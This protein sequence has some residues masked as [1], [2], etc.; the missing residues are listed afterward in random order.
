LLTGESGVGKERFADAI[1]HLSQRAT[2]PFVKVNCA[3]LSPMLVESE[4][5]GH[6]KGAFTG[7]TMDRKG[8]FEEAHGGTLLLDEVGELP[9]EMQAKLLRFLQEGEL[10]RIGEDRV[11]K[12]DVRVI[13]ATN[14]NLE[15]EIQAG[16]FRQDLYYRL[17]GVQMVIPPLRERREDIPL[18]VEHILDK[19][20]TDSPGG[21]SLKKPKVAEEVMLHFMEHD[22]PGNVRELVQAL[23]LAV[24]LAQKTGEIS[25]AECPV[26]RTSIEVPATVREVHPEENHSV[27]PF[28]FKGFSEEKKSFSLKELEIQCITGA[29]EKADG[30]ITA[31]AKLLEID[32]TTLW[33][34][35]KKYNMKE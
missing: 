34:K 35:L 5:F 16:H 26:R 6:R 25:S 28:V 12:V 7:A 4:L 33:R 2:K 23:R 3:A 22:W 15:R 24:I 20:I 27:K 14:R 29:L 13:A 1:H 10:Q 17:L 21:V 9:L 18:L 30:N 19:I 31:A 32:R 11:R 8:S